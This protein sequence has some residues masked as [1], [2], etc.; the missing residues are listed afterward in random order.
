[1]QEIYISNGNG[2]DAANFRVVAELTKI[3]PE[4]MYA[5]TGSGLTELP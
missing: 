1:M 3:P 2:S 5:L 4:R